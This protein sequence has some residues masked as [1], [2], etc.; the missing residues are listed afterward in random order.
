M[1]LPG[2]ENQSS[3]SQ[4]AALLYN[5]RIYSIRQALKQKGKATGALEIQDLLDLGHLDQYHYFGSQACDR[6]I[7]YLAL[8]SNSRV[9]DIGSGVGGPARYIS[10]KTGCQLQCVELRQD[11]SEIAQELT[12]RMGLDGRIQYLTGNI[13]SS[14]IIDSLLPNSFDNIISFLSLLHIEERDKVLEICFRALK[15][16]GY[17]YVEDYVANCTLT[18]EVKTTLREVFKSA[19]VPTR[20]T[21]RHH[22]ERAGF[23]DICFIDLTTGWKRCKAERYQKFTESKEE[24]IKLFGEDIFEHRSRLYR[25]GRDMF[26]GGSI[27]GALIVAKKPSV[28]QIHLIP[29]TYFS[30]FTSVYNEQYH[31]FLEDGS[32][33]ALRHFKTKTLEHY[34]A[35][36]SDTKGNS[37]ELINTSEQ[38]SSNPHIS[39]EKNNQTGTICLPEANL[40]VQFEVTAQF[41]W[42]VPGEENQRSVIHQPQLQCTVHTENG[43]QKAE[44]Y[45]KIYEGN[46]PRFW[47]YHFVY[48]FFP[49]YGIIWSAD[50]TFGQE[51]NNHFNFLNAYQKEKWLRG[52]KSDHG[53]TSVHACIQNKMYDLS[54]DIGFATWSTILRNRTS[55]MESKLSLE[56]REAILTI[57]DR[58]VSKGVCLKES[59]FGTIA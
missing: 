45:C 3:S 37:R 24:S 39:I 55:A 14:Q 22:F 23:T 36:W 51:R 38:R 47:G 17:I 58:E 42:G 25:V 20:E 30:V 1:T 48:A 31:F 35:W 7:N 43:T 9:L 16:N 8:N 13:L 28:A 11:F 26:Q 40:E 57:D 5:W 41:T 34:S 4:D 2:L 29:E 15:E 56:Y 52:E 18:P 21:Y 32:L 6:A 46:Y 10:Y 19:Y 12:Q 49:D 50:G 44:G 27:G 54:F 53:K 33:L 59:C